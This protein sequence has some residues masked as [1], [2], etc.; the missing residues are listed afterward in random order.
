LTAVAAV[1][2]SLVT[3]AGPAQAYDKGTC[4]RGFGAGN[5]LDVDTIRVDTTYADLGDLPH[6]GLASGPRG[7]AVVCW[8]TDGRVAVVGRV[9]FESPHPSWAAELHITVADADPNTPTAYDYPVSGT[10]GTV[11]SAE[12]R[13][14]AGSPSAPVVEVELDLRVWRS[15]S[16]YFTVGQGPGVSNESFPGDNCNFCFV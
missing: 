3:L 1:A 14:V 5:V 13:L 15:S 12:L 11:T 9:F 10:P 6:G 2:G 7:D 8:S 4:E 16:V